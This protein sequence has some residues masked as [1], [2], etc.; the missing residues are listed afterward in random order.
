MPSIIMNS[1]LFAM[2]NSY[3]DKPVKESHLIQ[4]LFK[5]KLITVA[6]VKL[7]CQV[8]RGLEKNSTIKEP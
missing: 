2:Y 7:Y 8:K 6:L 1:T 4:P 3:Q 5:S